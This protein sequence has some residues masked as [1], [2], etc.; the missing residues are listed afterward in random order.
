MTELE[1]ALQTLG[2]ELDFPATP[3]VA[4]AVRTRLHRPARGRWLVFGIALAAVAFGI[5]MAVPDAR[6]A[7]LRFFHIGAATVEQVETLPAA[8]ER[9]LVA[10]LGPAMSRH[11]AEIAGHQQ[12][13]LPEIDG[14]AP[15][16]YYAKPGFV[17]TVLKFRGKPVL[18]VELRDDQTALAKKLT[19]PGTTVEPV[20]LGQT[21][22]WLE[23]GEHVLI[24]QFGVGGVKQI[25]TR[26]A[27]NVLLWL[28]GTT[29]YR[30]EG[31]LNKR[32]MLQLA[33]DITR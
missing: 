11:E 28:D 24:W 8:Q 14:P 25:Q 12:I 9:P 16:R 15:T 7:I 1:R 17:A 13:R 10:G 20:Q 2:G 27:G 5:A 4:S 30:L 3:D 33:R 29:T 19:S 31:D 23:G 26:L 21:G 32:Q 18:L 22:L 6:S